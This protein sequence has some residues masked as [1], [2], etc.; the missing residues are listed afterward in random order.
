MSA[1]CRGPS[2][3]I[4]RPG[5]FACEQA[6]SST[7]VHRAGPGRRPVA[8]AEV[9]QA[10]KRRRDERPMVHDPEAAHEQGSDG[11]DHLVHQAGRPENS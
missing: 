1:T 2:F 4:E 6:G 3:E 10:G 11:Q 5:P 9:R 8:V 7:P